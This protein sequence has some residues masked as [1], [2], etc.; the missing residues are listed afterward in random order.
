[1]IKALIA[2]DQTL[3]RTMLEEVLRMDPEIEVMPSATNGREAVQLALKHKPD[4]VLM[5][6]QMPECSGIKALRE[7]KVN[8]PEI[9]VVMLTTFEDG[10]SIVTSCQAGSDGYLVKDMKPDVLIMA[11]KCIC[12]NIFLMHQ[13]AYDVIFPSIRMDPTE[14]DGKVTCGS[15]VF[16]K[17]DVQIIQL[18][19]DGKTNR[20]IAQSLS[21]SEGTI[22]NRVSGILSMTGLSDRTQICVFALKN[23]II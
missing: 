12:N 5:D 7:I 8:C 10:E 13:G 22:K 15:F 23:R 21:Y 2:D 4:I 9:K 1:M 14:V 3:F 20:E 11:L 18:I 6:I 16:D 17:T 19:S